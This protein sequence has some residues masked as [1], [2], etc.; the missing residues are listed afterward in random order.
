M[1]KLELVVFASGTS[2]GGGSGFEK[3][4]EASQ[5]EILDAEI[6]AVVSNHAEGG[7]RQKANRLNIPFIHFPKPW[8]TEEYQR[9]ARETGANF[10]ALSGWLKLV[11]GLDLST[12][13]NSKTIFNI[14]P[15]PLPQ[16]GGPGL[17]GHHVH[18]AVIESFR[19]GEITHTAI[20]MHFVT[21]E[22]DK[23]PVFLRLKIRINPNDTP[24]TLAQRVNE[25]EHVYQPKITNLVVNGSIKWDGVN[26]D[27]LEVPSDYSI[28]SEV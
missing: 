21:E 14:H 4:A 5:A 13:F 25:Y 11:R 7:V 12:N 17:Y 20:T 1:N 9:I 24:E 18:E 27:S 3:L 10:F 22:Y 26:S 16:F 23:G 8:T 19:R 28:E 15:G 2:E 6:V